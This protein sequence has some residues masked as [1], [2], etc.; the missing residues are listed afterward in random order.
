MMEDWKQ[1]IAKYI[2]MDNHNRTVAGN[3]G[4]YNGFRNRSLDT[5]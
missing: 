2:G 5:S 4:G 1:L 3:G